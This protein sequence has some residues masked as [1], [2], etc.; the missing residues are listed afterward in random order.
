MSKVEVAKRRRR[1]H[2]EEFR[3]GAVAAC[4]AAGV[5]IAAVALAHGINANL[6]RKWIKAAEEAGALGTLPEPRE[7]ARAVAVPIRVTPAVIE[8]GPDIRLDVRRGSLTVQMA[9]PSSE[10]EALGKLLGELLR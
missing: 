2:S 8:H 1:N 3:A 7:T 9:W 5:S 4:R 10:A 6:L